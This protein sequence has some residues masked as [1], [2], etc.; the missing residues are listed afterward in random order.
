MGNE[1]NCVVTFGK[2]KARGKA[3]LESSE[4]IFRSEDGA[5]RLKFSFAGIKSATAADGQLRLE[6]PEGT[7]VFELGANAA[8]WCDKI[9]HPKTRIDKLGIKPNATVSLIGNFDADFLAEL[10][11]VTKN[12]SNGKTAADTEW[13]FFAA[14]SSKDSS[15]ISKFAKALKGAAALW[16]VYPKGQKQI[17]ENDVIAAGRKSGLKD[18]KVAGFSPTHTGLKFVIPIENR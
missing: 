6:A 12:V 9:L 8:K 1:A 18:V 11:S 3:L 16:I 13:I 7:A 2:Q 4:L 15:Q 10:H 5:M 17:T 14:D